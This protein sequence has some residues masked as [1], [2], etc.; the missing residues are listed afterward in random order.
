MAVKMLS[1]LFINALVGALASDL[2]TLPIRIAPSVQAA[3]DAGR[4]VVALESTIISH[5]MPF[6][7]NLQTA[8]EVEE[9]IEKCGA[10]AATIAILDG[11]CCIGL[12]PEELDRFAQLGSAGQVSKI[13]RRDVALCVA[14]GA[15]GGTT[16]S[17]TMLLAHMAGIPVF[18][19]GGIGGVH[20][21]G[22]D[23]MDVSADLCELGRTPV[24]VVSAGVKSILDIPRT[25]EYLETQGVCV[26]ALGSGEFPAFF[27]RASGVEAP[28]RVDT[29]SEA[30]AVAHAQHR[31]GLASGMLV[32]VPIPV[33]AEADAA[34]VQGAID[35]ALQEAAAQQI[36][37]RAITPFL[38]KR[39]AELSGGKSLA[40]N[41][42]LIKNNAKAGAE[43]AV[44]LARLRGRIGGG[45]GGGAD[46]AG[47]AS[48]EAAA[49]VSAS[50]S[51][52]VVGGCVADLVC[53]PD[54]GTELLPRP[55]SPG[56]LECTPGGVGRNIAEAL[57]R[58]GTF[59]LLV[60]AVGQD[61]M[62]S[63]LV[64]HLESLAS[65]GSPLQ[66]SG[67]RRLS[68]GRTATY[69]AMMDGGGDL[70]AA[71]ADMEIHRHISMH[72]I[73][74]FTTQIRSAPLCIA[75][76]N[77][78]SEALTGLAALARAAGTPLWLEPTSVPKAALACG[79][80]H[81]KG[82]LSA[83]TYVSPNED[84][85]CAMAAAIGSGEG[86]LSSS[87]GASDDAT[88]RAAAAAL[89]RAGVSHVVVTR[90]ARGILWARAAE[91]GSSTPAPSDGSDVWMEEMPAFNLGEQPVVST[92]GAG[93]CFVAGAAWRLQQGA[94]QRGAGGERMAGA[95]AVREALHAGLKAAYWSVMD[96]AAVP[97]ALKAAALAK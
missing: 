26:V 55:S 82:L 91:P 81:A 90:G 35:Q 75:D 21:G 42:A 36:S 33:D 3:L 54:S 74:E 25:L 2:A 34:L 58:L 61:G 78:C 88:V 10:T 11:V 40:S 52:V 65:S 60:S 49:P 15:H 5:G 50:G 62:G 79:W 53:C 51:P 6:P 23:S 67:V 18:V 38:L 93:D 46:R 7:A 59:P 86:G 80:L 96:E 39:I 89:V 4:P 47:A 87:H 43:I 27:T 48:S 32:G 83:L 70:S 73:Q 57:A 14:K 45:G 72:L 76:A 9:V 13:S 95:D 97:D 22:E 30:A 64:E 1:T 8:K 12:T 31:L 24:M 16:V 68:E 37:G 69:T 28:A 17:C 85:V 19:T 94:A 71:V 92:R 29:T 66:T 77:L 84:E 44:E 20:R 56:R 41:I 63:L